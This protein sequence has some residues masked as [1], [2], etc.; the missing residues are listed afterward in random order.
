MPSLESK[1][2][3]DIIRKWNLGTCIEIL[4][5][6]ESY[7]NIPQI[8]YFRYDLENVLVIDDWRY[9]F[10]LVGEDNER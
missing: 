6:N 1:I 8:F 2:F 7:D 10:A 9:I 3:V 4:V 5:G